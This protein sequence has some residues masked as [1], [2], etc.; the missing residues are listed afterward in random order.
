[1]P[2]R[3]V[4][5]AKPKPKRA[6]ASKPKAG[7]K[8]HLVDFAL[9]EDLARWEAT[10]TAFIAR[11][12]EAAGAQGVVL[13][14]SGGLDSAVVAALCVKA[15]GK[16][17][18]LCVLMPADGSDPK[19]EA[20]ARLSCKSLGLTPILRP[21][22]PLVAGLAKTLPGKADKRVLGN[23]KARSRMMVL[24]AEGQSRGYL[25][26]GT[27]N[28]S[29]LLTGYFTKHGDGGVDLQP[30]GDL[31]KTQ[32]RALGRHLGVPKPILAK[33]PSAGLFP[34][35]TD[36]REMG[37]S[38]ADLDAILR[39]MELNHTAAT[40]ARKTGLAPSLVAKVDKMVRLTE[41]KR[42]LALIPKI[43]A[44]TVGIDWRRPVHWDG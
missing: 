5:R 7:S 23:A 38:Y 37:L 9:P 13:G 44:R 41:H 36:E 3:A 29:E 43:G 14:A 22:G 8:R 27:G 30:I 17:K 32:V 6:A 21:V 16:R 25:V 11:H 28:K 24:Y 10:I 1:V 2:K 31:Y 26:C 39:G 42:R 4:S 18:V 20:H 12:V 40:I 35:Q 34:G 33:P 15:L 19:D